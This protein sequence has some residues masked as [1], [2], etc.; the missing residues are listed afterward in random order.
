ML[1]KQKQEL[2]RTEGRERQHACTQ[3]NSSVSEIK[4]K[5]KRGCI[6]IPSSQLLKILD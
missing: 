3:T 5:T 1:C 6:V 4:T 2:P